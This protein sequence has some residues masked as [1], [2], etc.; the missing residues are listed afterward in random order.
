MLA[1]LILA[2]VSSSWM[3]LATVLIPLDGPPQICQNKYRALNT[4]NQCLTLF[5]T[6]TKNE[7]LLFVNHASSLML[8][9]GVG[10]FVRHGRERLVL[11]IFRLLKKIERSEYVAIILDI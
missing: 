5:A 2:L 6:Y 3:F 4:K 8:A 1:Q 10:S 7:G 11:H 9:V